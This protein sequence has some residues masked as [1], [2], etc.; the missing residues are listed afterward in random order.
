VVAEPDAVAQ[1]LQERFGDD[2]RRAIVHSAAD[3]G[4][5]VWRTVTRHTAPVQAADPVATA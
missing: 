5:E 1:A 3:P 4:L 2:T